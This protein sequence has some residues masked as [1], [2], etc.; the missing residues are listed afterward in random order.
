MPGWGLKTRVVEQGQNKDVYKVFWEVWH[1]G[2]IPGY[3]PEA[4]V[5][6]YVFP[7]GKTAKLMKG[8]NKGAAQ[9][10][11]GEL[12]GGLVQLIFDPTLPKRDISKGA[13]HRIAHKRK[14]LNS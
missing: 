12:E 14:H 8:W 11:R 7:D 4:N 9:V 1:K 5:V 3:V 2:V 10:W 6:E 13:W